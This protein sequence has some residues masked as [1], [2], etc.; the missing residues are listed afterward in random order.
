MRNKARL[1][2]TGST[3]ENGRVI[4]P[5]F[6]DAVHA[7]PYVRPGMGMNV[8]MTDLSWSKQTYRVPYTVVLI[9]RCLAKPLEGTFTTTVVRTSFPSFKSL[10]TPLYQRGRGG[11]EGA[12]LMTLS[13]LVC[14]LQSTCTADDIVLPILSTPIYM[15]SCC[16]K[17]HESQLKKKS[18]LRQCVHFFVWPSSL[19][20]GPI[21]T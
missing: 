13:H 21:L 2:I 6:P 4:T 3:G 5:D 18:L 7:V 16:W 14:L 12:Q 17:Y 1:S 11:G 10:F 19:N 8:S 9:V 15:H 20:P